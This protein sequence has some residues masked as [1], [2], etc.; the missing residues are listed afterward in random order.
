V[1]VKSKTWAE[2]QLFGL[3]FCNMKFPTGKPAVEIKYIISD[4]DILTSGTVDY[5]KDIP[6]KA[7]TMEI[8]VQRD[9]VT[10]GF[11]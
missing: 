2:D 11:D 5:S 3:R 7:S 6:A 9:V 4:E 8:Q 10:T 1:N